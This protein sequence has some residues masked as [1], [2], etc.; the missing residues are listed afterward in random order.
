[1]FKYCRTFLGLHPCGHE[2]IV[3]TPKRVTIGKIFKNGSCCGGNFIDILDG[4]E[5]IIY[6]IQSTCCQAAKVIPRFLSLFG[7]NKFALYE[8][9]NAKNEIVGKI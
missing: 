9:F 8:I 7:C 5:K 1:M 2:V 4:D 6:K 3:A